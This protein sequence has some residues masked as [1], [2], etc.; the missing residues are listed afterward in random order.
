MVVEIFAWVFSYAKLD[1]VSEI[2]SCPT[3]LSMTLDFQHQSS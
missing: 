3:S 1:Y 2:P